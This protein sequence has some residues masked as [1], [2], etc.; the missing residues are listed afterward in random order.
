MCPPQKSLDCD[1]IEGFLN[2]AFHV[3]EYEVCYTYED[4][5]LMKCASHIRTWNASLHV[6]VQHFISKILHIT[7]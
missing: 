3:V 7:K 2:E 6:A 1:A 5:T 4:A